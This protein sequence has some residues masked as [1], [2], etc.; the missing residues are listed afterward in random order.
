MTAVCRNRAGPPLIWINRVM[1][2]WRKRGPAPICR[3][4]MQL[5]P[6]LF[7]AP[8]R[9]PPGFVYR[10][11]FVTAEEERTLVRALEPLP[12][13]PFEFHGYL[14]KRRVVSYG[15]RYDF[16]GGGLQQTD[17]LP[18]FLK[19][20]RRKAAALAGLEDTDLQQAL[21]IEYTPGAGIGWHKDRP[22]FEEVV[23]ISLL[24]PCTFR[25]RRKAGTKWERASLVVEPR[26]AYLL[27]GQARTEWEHGIP[28]V[29]E[30]RYSLTFRNFKNH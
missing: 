17:D 24:S 19:P 8:L 20:I 11:D 30:L 16:N 5:Q 13:R 12:F 1:R 7:E 4:I 26:S 14:G 28:A 15:W 29:N 23:G 27:T 9:L 18:E 25:L 10:P 22:V 21:L 3:C 2:D 6:S